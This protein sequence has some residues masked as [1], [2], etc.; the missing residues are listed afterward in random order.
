MDV[1]SLL[2]EHEVRQR[3]G[4]HGR[5]AR[6][7][8]PYMLFPQNLVERAAKY[9]QVNGAQRLEQLILWSGYATSEGVVI[10]GLLL[11]TT[12]AT[13][14]WVHV[15]PSEQ[16][17]IVTWLHR[18]GQLLFAESHTHGSGPRA[19]DMS[20]EDRRH[21]AGRQDGFLTMIVPDYALH[22]IDF[23]RVGVWECRNLMWNKWHQR[24]VR[25][26]IR[27][28]EEEEARVALDIH[29]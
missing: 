10:A 5:S 14:G 15:L 29:Q 27:V 9:L 16:P 28:V 21:P 13:W 3:L 26:R 20:D 25:T 2:S 7:S 17:Q 1:V 24:D 8:P 22:G 12:E 11:P 6:P 18:H 4:S 23:R 19:T